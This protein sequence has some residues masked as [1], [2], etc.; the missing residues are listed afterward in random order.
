MCYNHSRSDYM[1]NKINKDYKDDIKKIR[2]FLSSRP[3]VKGCFCYGIG[4]E[5]TGKK[6]NIKVPDD[7]KFGDE[8]ALKKLK[9]PEE[10]IKSSSDD[11]EKQTL[12]AMEGFIHNLNTMHARAGA[13]VPFTSINSIT[14]HPQI[15]TGIGRD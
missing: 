9:I 13:Q 14:G 5:F 15:S 1:L 6:L 8:K 7:I 4:E 10:V 2:L 3:Q 11:V 12:Q